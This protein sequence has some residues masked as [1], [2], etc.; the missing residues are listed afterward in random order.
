MIEGAVDANEAVVGFPAIGARGQRREI[1]AAVDTGFTGFLTLPPEVVSELELEFA[2]YRQMML[3][4][5]S[6]V[7]LETYRATVVW[8]GTRRHVRVS[9]TD[10]APTVGMSMLEGF[11]LFI[12]AR[13]GGRVLIQPASMEVL[14]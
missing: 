10:N 5:G 11:D 1:D 7:H 9:L 3:A 8:D 14:P 13:Q 12:Q 6:V 4:D 2:G